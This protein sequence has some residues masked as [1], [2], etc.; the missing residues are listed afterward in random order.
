M[1]DHSATQTGESSALM[2]PANSPVLQRKCDCGTHTMGEA[3]CDSCKAQ[4]AAG[5]IQR[6]ATSSAPAEAPPIVEDV[7]RSPGQP[8]DT[9]TR[10]FFEPRFGQDFSRVRVH[11]DQRAADSA[12]AISAKAYTVG[13]NVVVANRN[14]PPD[15]FENR[16]LLAHELAH[17]VQQKS[18]PANTGDTKGISIGRADDASEV[19]ADRVADSV[20]NNH[21]AATVTAARPQTQ[22]IQRTVDDPKRYQ[23]THTT[24]FVK[25]P[26]GG[27]STLLTWEDPDPQKKIKG[28]ADKLFKQAKANIQQHFIDHPEDAQGKV[29]TRTTEAD[30]DTDAVDISKQLRARFPYMKVT[31]TPAEIESAVNVMTPT[32]TG[33]QD[34]LRE[35]MAN[36]LVNFSDVEDYNISETDPRFVALLDRL[37][38]DSDVGADL[39][40]FASRQSGFQRGQGTKREIFVHRG[41]EEK[42]RKKV[43]F[44]ELTHFYVHPIFREW[45]ATTVNERFYNEGFTEYLARLAMPAEI[46]AIAKGYQDRVDRVTKEVAAHVPDDDIARAF[47]AGEVWRIETRSKISRREVG[48]QLGLEETL[49]EKEEQE[50]SRTG[51]GINQ[52]VVEGERYR[53]MNLGYDQTKPKPEHISFFKEVKKR[54]LDPTQSNGVVFEGHASTAG[55]LPYNLDLSLSRARAFYKMARDEGVAS[56][57]LIDSTNPPHFGET[58][59]TAEE[60][61]PATRAFNR[62]VELKIQPVGSTKTS[63]KLKKD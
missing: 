23:E 44:H 28:T 32:L 11:T 48:S 58:K 47:F 21:P 38:S 42:M 22:A 34:Y 53:F 51:P 54:H 27:G 20:M 40:V 12:A 52:V 17:V 50:A 16:R 62:R 9:S 60:E 31:A 8:L 35:W 19:A 46:L 14:S 4:A 1:A 49:S 15:T 13:E 18:A 61:D 63:T 55:T 2:P 39:K 36:K 43:L 29:P 30:L 37:L 6:A 59:V 7:L 24:L 41:V 33:S 26:G 5:H 25:P 56:S 3:K 10:N 57:R 45:V